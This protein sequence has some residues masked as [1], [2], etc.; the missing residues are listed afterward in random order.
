MPMGGGGPVLGDGLGDE[1]QPPAEELAYWQ[2]T[3]A[4]LEASLGGDEAIWAAI[5]RNE[6]ILVNRV[7][8]QAAAKPADHQGYSKWEPALITALAKSLFPRF[9]QSRGVVWITLDGQDQVAKLDFGQ[10]TV[11]CYQGG[12]FRQIANTKF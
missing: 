7:V 5:V 11:A 3:P 8:A 10:R 4:H 12:G 9:G 2:V 6:R 1:D